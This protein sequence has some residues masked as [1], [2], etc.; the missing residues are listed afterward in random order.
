MTRSAVLERIETSD[1]QIDPLM[2]NFCNQP[3]EKTHVRLF[4]CECV[5]LDFIPFRLKEGQIT[6]AT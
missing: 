4:G 6:V 5:W 1:P 2:L 3:E